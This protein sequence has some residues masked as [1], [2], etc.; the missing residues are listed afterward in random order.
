MVACIQL[1]PTGS[2]WAGGERRR[3]REERGR[4][5]EPPDCRR[6]AVP[7]TGRGADTGGQAEEAVAHGVPHNR[8]QNDKS[9]PGYWAF[10][11][12][13]EEI[14]KVQPENDTYF[15]NIPFSVSHGQNSVPSVYAAFCISRRD[16]AQ[17]SARGKLD[18]QGGRESESSGGMRWMGLLGAGPLGLLGAL[19]WLRPGG[20]AA[21]K[22]Y[23]FNTLVGT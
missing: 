11:Y 17:I 15:Q 13:N 5:D 16:A 1:K 4:R 10:R 6:E 19:R 9:K 8:K 20:C 3:G 12:C 14:R 22:K 18:R 21:E 2:L 7:E 23:V